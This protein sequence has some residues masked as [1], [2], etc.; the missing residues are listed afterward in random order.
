MGR[1]PKWPDKAEVIEALHAA[2]EHARSAVRT[3]SDE[4]LDRTTTMFGQ[5]STYRAVLLL[6]TTH[7]HEHLGQQIAYAR[8]N[9]VVPPWSMGGG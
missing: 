9:G 6:M 5:P 2:F 4:D 1:A 3:V 8:A 7:C